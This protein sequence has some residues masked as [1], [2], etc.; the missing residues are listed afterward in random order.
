[1]SRSLAALGMVSTLA[2]T[3]GRAVVA[4]AGLAS[5]IVAVLLSFVVS[6]HGKRITNLEN[7]EDDA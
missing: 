6:K 1:M 4:S 7:N 5:L 3:S 2:V